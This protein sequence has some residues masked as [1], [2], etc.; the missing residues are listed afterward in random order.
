MLLGAAGVVFVPNK[1][2]LLETKHQIQH[3]YQ[4]M[5]AYNALFVLL[6][7]RTSGMQ[8]SQLYHLITRNN[9]V[10]TF[11]CIL[12]PHYRFDAYITRF[13][14]SIYLL[15]CSSFSKDTHCQQC[16]QLIV[17][18]I[19]NSARFKKSYLKAKSVCFINLCLHAITRCLLELKL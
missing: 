16:L 6:K 15:T 13:I 7:G 18:Q 14:L 11:C 2:K 9:I 4:W 3:Y 10:Y 5:A 8:L 12:P 17:C 1:T 19:S